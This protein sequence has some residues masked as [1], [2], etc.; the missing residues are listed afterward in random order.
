MGPAVVDLINAKLDLLCDPQPSFESLFRTGKLK[1]LA[2]LQEEA[3][4]DGGVP[5]AQEQGYAMVV[6]N[7][8]GLFAP[9]NLPDAP[10]QAMISAVREIVAD[11]KF[12][13]P[14]RTSS[15]RPVLREKTQPLEVEMSLRLGAEIYKQ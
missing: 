2:N 11:P 4:V 6:P 7:W 1:Y 5:T 10:Y 8:T 3:T 9:R 14:L 12:M 13:D 15:T